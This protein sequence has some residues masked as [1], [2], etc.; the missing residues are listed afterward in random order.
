MIDFSR[1]RNYYIACGY[2]DMRKQ[3]DGLVAA[4]QMQY[5]RELDEISLFLFYGRKADRV[6]AL[7]WDG[8]GYVL[9]YKRLNEKIFQWPRSEAEL[10][11]VTQQ[12]FRWLMEGLSITQ[13]KASFT[14]KLK[15]A[16]TRSKTRFVRSSSAGK[17]GCFPTPRRALRQALSF[18]P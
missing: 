8:T 12:E 7:Y 14:V 10:K 11:Q 13:A 16:T 17:V 6:K 15:S 5:Q 2:T 9:L 1:V 18:T 4:V 3:I